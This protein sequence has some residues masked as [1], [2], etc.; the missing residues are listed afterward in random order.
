MTFLA[1]MGRHRTPDPYFFRGQIG[2][3]KSLGVDLV[4]GSRLHRIRLRLG[5][6]ESS[7]SKTWGI[8]GQAECL[9][10]RNARYVSIDGSGRACGVGDCTCLHNDP[11]RPRGDPGPRIDRIPPTRPSWW[12]RQF[13]EL[14]KLF[15]LAPSKCPI[16]PFGPLANRRI[17]KRLHARDPVC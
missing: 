3:R 6:P 13:R 5:L 9:A 8:S 11:R 4:V 16:D 12:R 17:L 14:K 15:F 10:E 7:E 2:S 1:G